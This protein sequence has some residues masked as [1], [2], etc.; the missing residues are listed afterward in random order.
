M[1]VWMVVIFYAMFF[2]TIFCIFLQYFVTG[3]SFF[4]A[5]FCLMIVF[6][7]F[8][9]VVFVS[10]FSPQIFCAK[11]WSILILFLDLFF[12]KCSIIRSCKEFHPFR[13][14]K[15]DRVHDRSSMLCMH[16]FYD[17]SLYACL[18]V[19]I[20]F[21]SMHACMCLHK[22]VRTCACIDVRL[23][24]CIHLCMYIRMHVYSYASMRTKTYV[25]KSSGDSRQKGKFDSRVTRLHLHFAN[26]HSLIF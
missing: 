9:D 10:V 1:Y 3:V 14:T 7:M 24:V 25:S 20:Y 22:Y 23:Y 17:V 21:A 11:F 8:L 18:Y 15:Q 12:F 5:M 26:W 6:F 13:I 4:F 16:V 19:S 2:R